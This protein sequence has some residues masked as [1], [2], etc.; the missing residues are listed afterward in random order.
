MSGVIEHYNG[1]GK[2]YLLSDGKKVYTDIAA[3]FVRSERP[4]A[5]IIASPYSAKIVKNILESGHLAATEFDYL[6]FG[7]EGYSRVCEVQLVRKRIAS[8]LIKSGTIELGGRR[9]F[10]MV[11]PKE[12]YDATV[13]TAIDGIPVTLSG[14][15]IMSIIS[16]WYDQNLE[17]GIAE[18]YLRYLKPQAT[19]FK[20]IA[21]MNIHSLIDWFK[22]RMCNRAQDEIRDLATKMYHLAKQAY[23]DIF[24]HAGPNCK[25]LGYCPEGQYQCKQMKGI[26]P[27]KEEVINN[28]K[29]Y[30]EYYNTHTHDTNKSDNTEL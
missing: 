30:K 15:D 18:T 29:K 22:I 4:V 26:V 1:D 6:I 25:V 23:P 3:R 7:I 5:E 13:D 8:Y 2:V 21:G 9:A 20:A 28:F 10:S 12:I 16:Q 24:E 19:E 14:R 11:A 17:K 27:T